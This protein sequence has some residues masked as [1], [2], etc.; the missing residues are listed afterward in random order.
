VRRRELRR[1][2]SSKAG[3]PYHYPESF[4]ELL[5]CVRLL[6]R[7]H[8]LQADRGVRLIPIRVRGG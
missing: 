1:A 7:P 2:N 3:E 6:F 8:A 4:T 5:A